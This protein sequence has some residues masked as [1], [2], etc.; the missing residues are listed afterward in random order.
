MRVLQGLGWSVAS[1]LMLL[2]LVLAFAWGRLRG[3]NTAQAAALA[4]FDQD[5]KPAKGR[6]AFPAVW[7]SNY[8]VPPDQIDAVYAANRPLIEKMFSASLSKHAV[9]TDPIASIAIYYPKLAPLTFDEQKLLCA[10]RDEDC[11]AK[12]RAHRMEISAL[13]AKHARRLSSDMA[14]AGDDYEWNDLPPSFLAVPPY[15]STHNMWLTSA[16]LDFVNGQTRVG[17]ENV[18][19]H[20]LTMRRLHAHNNTLLGTMVAASKL[21]GAASLFAHML[22][23]LPADQDVPDACAKAFA[24]VETADVDLCASMQWEF[25]YVD[26]IYLMV[27]KEQIRW[28]DRL[29]FS[30]TITRRQ[31]ASQFARMCSDD[32]RSKLLSDQRFTV[33]NMPVHSDIVDWVS[34]ITGSVLVG[35]PQRA[36]VDY[37]NRQQDTAATLRLV[38]TILWLEHTRG[39]GISLQDRLQQRPAWMHM[40]DDRDLHV[41]KDNR[42][43]HMGQ[44]GLGNADMTDWP[45]PAG[46]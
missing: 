31:E 20:A 18:C 34:N 37:L 45:L 40:A 23:E 14:F 32:T 33:G 41:S 19:T 24:P 30:R 12:V 36:Y 16:A 2:V 25:R 4:L 13:L 39:N 35:T 22:A 15:T 27:N 26:G 7:L 29:G 5:M 43:V 21:S 17:L 46:L 6:N 1:L 8:D 10:R 38:A 3:P 42:S 11:L 28:W 9:L 44:H